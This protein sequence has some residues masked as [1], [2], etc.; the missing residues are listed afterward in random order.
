MKE[1][2]GKR[3]TK[4][5]ESVWILHDAEVVSFSGSD[6]TLSC[7]SSLRRDMYLLHVHLYVPLTVKMTYFAMTVL[8]GKLL[9][10]YISLTMVESEDFFALF[11]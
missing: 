9:F 8:Q 3:K 11:G 7:D 10:K 5:K 1:R 2:D 4:R 6:K